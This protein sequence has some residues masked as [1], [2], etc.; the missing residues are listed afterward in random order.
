M[1]TVTCARIAGLEDGSSWSVYFSQ[2]PKG[3][4]TVIKGPRL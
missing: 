3:D 2:I 4:L 1:V